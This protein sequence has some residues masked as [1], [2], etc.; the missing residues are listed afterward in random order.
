MKIRYFPF[1]V[2]WFVCYL[3]VTILV[4]CAVQPT[5]QATPPLA[6]ATSET[7]TAVGQIILGYGDHSPVPNLPL[8]LG[9][10]SQGQPITYTDANGKFVLTGLPVGQTIDVVDDHLAFQFNITSSGIVDV[11]KFEYPLIHP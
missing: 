2:L 7:A 11:G 5:V 4:G 10:E 3:S 8:W 9:K 1:H 6:T